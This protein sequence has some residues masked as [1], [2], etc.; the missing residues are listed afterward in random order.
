[1]IGTGIGLGL[2]GYRLPALAFSPANVS[3]LKLWLDAAD[4]STMLQSSGGAA[5]S[6]NGDPVGVWLDKSG[7]PYHAT[8]SDGTRKPSF[9]T[10]VKNSRSVLRFD[11]SNDSLQIPGSASFLKFLHS[12]NATVFVAAKEFWFW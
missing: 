7:N 6:S 9:R 2:S 10:N 1:M 3:G 12:S 4:S 11:G 5:V 8:Q